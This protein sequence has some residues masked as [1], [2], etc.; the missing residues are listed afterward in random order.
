MQLD[1]L[2]HQQQADAQPALRMVAAVLE[3]MAQS[4]GSIARATLDYRARQR[5]AGA[6][7]HLR[8]YRHMGRRLAASPA[9]A[10]HTGDDRTHL[11]A[12]M[13][14]LL[15][16]AAC[17]AAAALSGCVAYGDPY[18]TGYSGYGYGY[19]AVSTGVYVSPGYSYGPGYYYGGRGTRDRDGD[20]VPNRV[21]RDRDGDGVRNRQDARPNNPWR[22]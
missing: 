8:A 4:C 6:G 18:Y 19:P 13:R 22:R 7:R 12:T 14:F 20:G 16:L 15:P 11:E 17:A 10:R 3:V 9:G 21:D 1:R 5:A 2:A